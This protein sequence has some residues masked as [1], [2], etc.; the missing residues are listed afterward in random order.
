MHHLTN[1]LFFGIPL[2]SYYINL[3]SSIISCLSCGNIYL[4]FGISLFALFDCNS[5]S[6]DFF[7][8]FFETLVILSA[9]LL[10]T[11]S[12]VASAVF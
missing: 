10:P 4:S 11:R 5:S 7:V 8:V 2:S 3:N 6:C 1:L 9:V 12:P